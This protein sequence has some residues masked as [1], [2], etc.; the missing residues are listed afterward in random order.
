MNK[1]VWLRGLCYRSATV[2]TI[3][4]ASLVAAMTMES[5]AAQNYAVIHNF[6]GGSDGAAATAGVIIDRGGRLYGTTTAGGDTGANCDYNGAGNGCGAVYRLT[7]HGSDWI[8]S[9]LYVFRGGQDGSS[10]W[11]RVIAGP[12]GTLFGTTMFGGGGP[13]VNSQFGMGCG[14]IFRLQPPANTCSS[15]PCPW[16][17]TILYT[18]DGN[19]PGT[20]GANPMSEV[21]FDA[22]GNFYGTASVGG[23]SGNGLVYKMTKTNRSWTYSVVYSFAG[24]P[25]DGAGPESGLIF[26]QAGNLYG[27]T[28][29]GPHGLGAIFELS[30]SGNSWTEKVL[31]SLNQN[32]S[33]G[34]Q[35]QGGLIL[36][37]GGN[38]YGTTTQGGAN[39]AGTVFEL[40][41]NG[42]S[43]TYSVL[44]N[45]PNNGCFS[46]VQGS[47]ASLLRDGAGQLYGTSPNGGLSGFC[48]AVFKL[49]PAQSG[50]VYNSLYDFQCN[51][52]GAF[53]YGNVVADG[54]GNLV[55][56]TGGGGSSGHGVVFTVSP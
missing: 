3:C 47:E 44:T 27:T 14:T 50:Y 20:H 40:S 51:A 49:T 36:D 46:C 18:F 19:G 30:P 11:A 34:G 43:W 38:L 21:V 42:N 28:A 8:T 13:C 33:D 2:L 15:D 5:A 16:H 48:G 12:D 54:S 32:G 53:P 25:N 35:P 45:F 6:S 4:C 29:S 31:Y 24:P 7:A 17:E 55:G 52:N 10:P 56:T 9:P 23:A 26:D 37:P 41:P 22:A 39:M 1:P